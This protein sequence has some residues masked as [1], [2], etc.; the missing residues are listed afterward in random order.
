MLPERSREARRRML[1]P[2]LHSQRPPHPPRRS[3]SSRAFHLDCRPCR[4]PA[5][6]SLRVLAGGSILS[7]AS[8]GSTTASILEHRGERRCG[9]RQVALSLPADE[10]EPP[11]CSC[12]YA[13]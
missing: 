4:L 6:G 3:L 13:T 11:V 10:R 9:L 8:V 1:L 2:I 7:W 12:G 5:R